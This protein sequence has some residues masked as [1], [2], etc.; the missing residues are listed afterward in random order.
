MYQRFTELVDKR[1]AFIFIGLL[2]ISYLVCRKAYPEL[3]QLLRAKAVA[4]FSGK[5]TSSK[6]ADEQ[7][8]AAQWENRRREVFASRVAESQR[9]AIAKYPALAVPRSEMNIRF[10]YRYQWMAKEDNARLHSPN[11]PETLADDCAKA[12]NVV[13]AA[14]NSAPKPPVAASSPKNLVFVP[15]RAGAPP[16][17]AAAA[18]A[19]SSPQA[20]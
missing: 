10:V 12:S 8:L 16:A 3:P 9:R 19:R 5:S 1:F 14:P 20:P 2:L 6:E 4:V 18:P 13:P 15:P 7:S 11:W 17:P